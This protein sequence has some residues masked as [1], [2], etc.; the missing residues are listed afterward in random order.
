MCGRFL[1]MT[2]GRDL[3]ERFEL[4]EIP[5]L[6]PRHNVAPTQMIAA[7]RL[8]A[9][10]G[11]RKLHMLKWGLIPF[12]SKDSTMGP[13]LINA[14]AETAAQKP[15]FRAAFRYRRCLIPADGFYE[16]KRDKG[17]KQP[18][19]IAM[20]DGNTFAFAGLWETWRE[21]QGELIESCTI[22]T[23]DANE[24]VLPIHD[25]MPV[26]LKHE[27]YPLWLDSAVTR[28]EL[29]QPLLSSYP[30]AEM[31]VRPAN[32]KVNKSSYDQPDCLEWSS[33]P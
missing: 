3:A 15:A 10:T 6:E 20:A 12:W 18:Y 11:T 21:P 19:L 24:V 13:K 1:L 32:P 5:S 23:T 26:I 8:E 9:Q 14:R 27:D 2:A 22:L 30:A 28:P 17:K 31:I 25:R 4:V 7:I 33:N 16:W 29:L